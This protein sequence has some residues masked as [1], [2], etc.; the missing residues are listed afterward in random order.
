MKSFFLIR[1]DPCF[2]CHPCSIASLG[3]PSPVRIH[4]TADQLPSARPRRC[5]MNRR[6]FLRA[7]GA[8]GAGLLLAN[9]AR[10]AAADKPVRVGLIG[11]GWYGKCDITQ[12]LKVFDA[13]VVSL[14]DVDKKM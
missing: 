1:L 6:H 9:D 7:A 12:L 3:D 8:A 11:C 14:C 4:S 13:E 2:P 10:L 5:P